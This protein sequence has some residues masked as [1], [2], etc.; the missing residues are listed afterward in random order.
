LGA[1]ILPHARGIASGRKGHG[2]GFEAR[3]LTA[4]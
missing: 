1:F 3:N 2:L 4:S